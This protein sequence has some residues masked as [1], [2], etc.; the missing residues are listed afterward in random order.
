MAN[1]RGKRSVPAV[2]AFQVGAVGYSVLVI[3]S[4]LREST[5]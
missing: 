1:Q 2:A 5:Q 3:T 4:G